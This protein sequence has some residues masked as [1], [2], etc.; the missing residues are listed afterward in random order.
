M[1]TSLIIVY[2]SLTIKNK[3]HN[4]SL[5]ENNCYI[6][7][8][9]PGTT[10]EEYKNNLQKIYTVNTVQTFWAVFNN[11]PNAGDMQV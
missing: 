7:R 2:T 1:C 6:N 9:I 10:T 8:A 11:I 4:T 5:I 3:L